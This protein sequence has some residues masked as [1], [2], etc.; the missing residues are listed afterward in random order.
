MKRYAMEIRPDKK[1]I[2]LRYTDVQWNPMEMG[3]SQGLDD[4]WNGADK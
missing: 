4:D 3:T 1:N 2:R